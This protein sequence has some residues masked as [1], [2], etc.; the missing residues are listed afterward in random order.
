MHPSVRLRAMKGLRE[1]R[2]R[3]ILLVAVAFSLLA[4]ACGLETVVYLIPPQFYSG[5]GFLTLQ[6][7]GNTNID[8]L[9]YQILYR[10]YDDSTAAAT[11]L[12][13]LSS[14]AANG[15]L[16]PD[17]VHQQL[18]GGSLALRPMLFEGLA[19]PTIL[20]IAATERG[21]NVSFQINQFINSWPVLKIQGTSS[22][23]LV[24]E[25]YRNPNASPGGYVSSKTFWNLPQLTI[26]D[27]DYTSSASQSAPS[28]EYI[29]MCAV[30]VASVNLIS[31]T[32][33]Y[34]TVLPSVISFPVP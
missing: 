7:S 18:V 15:G 2:G 30:G 25:T 1:G 17:V 31:W 24:P 27:S 10:I 16:S 22:T 9:G 26:G 11:A 8:F 20:P 34:P 12:Q 19:D 28:T 32:W 21:S 14:L 23:A 4:S 5:S 3:R 13:T 6:D 33:S 29:V